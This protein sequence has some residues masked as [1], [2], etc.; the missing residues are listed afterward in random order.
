MFKLATSNFVR[1]LG[2]GS[3][4]PKFGRGLGQWSTP[5]ILEHLLISATIESHNFTFSM[6]PRFG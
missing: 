1:I 6:W 5:K 3:S 2:S 4:M